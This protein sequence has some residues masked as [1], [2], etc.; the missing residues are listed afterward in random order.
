MEIDPPQGNSMKQKVEA[1]QSYAGGPLTSSIS[2]LSGSSRGIPSEKD[3]HF[4]YNFDQF[5]AQIDAI[6]E[7]SQSMLETIGNSAQVWGKQMTVPEADD[8]DDDEVYDWL[9]NVNDEVFERFDSSYDEFQKLRKEEEISGVRVMSSMADSDDGFHLVF[10]K[11][12]KKDGVSGGENLSSA[13]AVKMASRDK[14]GMGIKPKI[15]FHI[16]TI[17]RPQDEYKIIVNN[18]NQ[19]FEH[20][21][22]QRSDDGSKFIHP[23]ERLS[24]LD[25]V[26][27]NVSAIEPQKP[28]PLA[29]TPFKM[30]EDVRDLK[31]LAAKLKVADEFAVDL[32]HNHYRSFQGLTC[33]MQISTR[34]HDFVVDTLKLR[35]HIGPHLRDY[36]KDPTKKKVM[37]GSDRDIIW[38]QRDFGIYICNMF[39]TGQAS[40]VL[41]LERNSLEHLLQHYCQ[42]TANKEYQ[43]ADW[44]LRPL[45]AEMVKY[46]RE[47]THYLLYM[48][49]LMRKELDSAPKDPESTE[50]PLEEVYRRSYDIC[51]QLYEKEVLTE[52][53]YLYI[54]GLQSADFNAQQLAII[55]GLCE[56]RDVVARAEDESTGYILPNKTLID[57]G[58]QMPV[59]ANKLK[60]LVMSKHPYI[61]RNLGSV[62]SIIRHSMQNASAFEAVAEQLKAA[63]IEKASDE[64]EQLKAENLDAENLSSELLIGSPIKQKSVLELAKAANPNQNHISSQYNP[65][66]NGKFTFRRDRDTIASHPAP[67]A[68]AVVEVLKKPSR[69]FGALLGTSATKRKF[70]F[71]KKEADEIKVEQIKSSVNLPF[72]SFLGVGTSELAEKEPAKPPSEDSPAAVSVNNSGEPTNKSD[73]NDAQEVIMLGSSSDSDVEEFTSLNGKKEKSSK[74]KNEE[75]LTD[76]SSSLEKCFQ[77]DSTADPSSAVEF[78]PFDYEA[79]R[80]E[81]RFGENSNNDKNSEDKI[82]KSNKKKTPSARGAAARTEESGDFQQGR[83][84]QAFPASGNR[85]ATFRQ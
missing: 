65:K 51:M 52:S 80:K 31:E 43:N 2:K 73:N 49:D 78:E 69:A 82:D 72:Q 3:F 11:K 68:E 8:D 15:P 34:T 21:W 25:F 50:S 32:E 17:P 66:D 70:D 13:S 63:R 75:G 56:W 44:R 18:S 62:V 77:S 6:A 59:T 47:D 53:S 85:S 19:P 83:R 48:Y 81:V 41:K 60:K 29:S 38:L 14:K 61:E 22:L 5:K 79:A 36:F 24:F 20:V 30:V 76:L 58:K 40:R 35:V 45:P 55:A 42:V 84:R 27:K 23:L 7:T 12:K 54:Y 10:G 33:L 28:P 67:G 4:Y 71:G 74:N 37:H 26:D 39:D 46:A 57:I 1:L 16:P 64:A 9:V